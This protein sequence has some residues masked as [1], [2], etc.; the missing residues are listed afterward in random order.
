MEHTTG[1]EKKKH[2]HMGGK[3]ATD[4]FLRFGGEMYKNTWK[5]VQH[6]I[7]HQTCVKEKEQ[8]AS[9]WTTN[10]RGVP[11]EKQGVK[12]AGLIPKVCVSIV[13]TS[14]SDVSLSLPGP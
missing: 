4:D 3:S 5:V 8:K 7:L 9:S 1:E 12:T 10:P 6:C 2:A 14:P 13:A 11:S